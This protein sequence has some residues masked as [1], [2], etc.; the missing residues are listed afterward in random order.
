MVH[1]EAN[2]LLVPI[3]ALARYTEKAGGWSSGAY[4]DP[5]LAPWLKGMAALWQSKLAV[6]DRPLP[7]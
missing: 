4:A 6:G 2:S 7:G 3:P 1:N 5:E